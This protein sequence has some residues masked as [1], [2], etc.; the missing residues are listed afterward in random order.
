VP[1]DQAVKTKLVPKLSFTCP[2]DWNGMRGDDKKRFCEHCQLHVHNLSAMTTQEQDALLSQGSGRRCIA[3]VKR[4]DAIQVQ[5]GTWLMIQ[6]ASRPWR[7]VAA[8]LVLLLPSVFSGCA[9]RQP[10]PPPVAQDVK[11]TPQPDMSKT[12][13]GVICVP[14]PLWRRILFFW[15]K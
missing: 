8:A 1:I 4:A 5:T 14:P 2:M 10:P 3:Y 7:A 9:T 12:T 6:R 15:E 13:V 11:A